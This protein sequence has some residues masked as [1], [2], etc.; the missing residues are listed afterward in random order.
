[1]K[2]LLTILSLIAP[3]LATPLFLQEDELVSSAR[4]RGAYTDSLNNVV[5]SLYYITKKNNNCG[6]YG[7]TNESRETVIDKIHSKVFIDNSKNTRDLLEKAI[8]ND[9]AQILSRIFGD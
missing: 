5:Y 7:I 9:E 4:E 2:Y 6:F 3:A 1:M 8:L